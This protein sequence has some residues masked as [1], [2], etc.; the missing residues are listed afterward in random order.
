MVSVAS[1]SPSTTRFLQVSNE[2][3]LP[4]YVLHQSVIVA[5]AY[6]VVGLDLIVIEKYLL[7]VLTVCTRAGFLDSGST[8]GKALYSLPVGLEL[9]HFVAN[10]NLAN[11]PVLV[12][13]HTEIS[14]VEAPS[15]HSCGFELLEPN[16]RR[17]NTSLLVVR[18][19]S[20]RIS[21]FKSA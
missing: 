20:P 19:S 3:V 4:F 16:R 9:V 6:Y 17:V 11:Y 7:I 15:Y 1:I 14:A 21:W 2:L 8:V 18:A 13:T 12:R 10:A 5:I